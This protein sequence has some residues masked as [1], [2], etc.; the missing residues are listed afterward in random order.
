MTEQAKEGIYVYQPKPPQDD[1][2][3]FALGGLPFGA[4]FTGLTKDEAEIFA[5]H[6]NDICWMTDRCH[7]C[8]HRFAMDSSA[9][10]QCGKVAAAPWVPRNVDACECNRC[11]GARAGETSEA[12]GRNE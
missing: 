4:S 10:P 5:E 6:L 1:G 3:M 7:A 9:C 8:G 2:R 11:V 12:Q